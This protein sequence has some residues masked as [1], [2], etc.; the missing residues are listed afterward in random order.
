MWKYRLAIHELLPIDR[1]LKDLILNR[2]SGYEI[3]DY[4]KTAGYY[5]LLQDGLLKVING[6]TTTEEVLR[7]ATIE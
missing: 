7:V 1:E 5:T 3:G 4:M 2:A 6:V